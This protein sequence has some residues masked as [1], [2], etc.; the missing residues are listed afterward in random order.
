MAGRS[1]IVRSLCRAATN[2]VPRRTSLGVPPRSTNFIPLRIPI[3]HP[4]PFRLV[5]RELTSFRPVHGAIA[6]ACLVSKLPSE[7]GTSTEGLLTISVLSSGVMQ[8]TSS[9]QS[10][11]AE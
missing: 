7:A 11:I 6:S 4:S 5:R 8:K 1:A 3:L 9:L 2:S 10:G